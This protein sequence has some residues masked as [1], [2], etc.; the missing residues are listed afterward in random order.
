M[1]VQVVTFRL[2]GIDDAGFQV[3]CD[4]LAPAF[5]NVPGMLAKIWLADQATNTYGG[6]Y[7]WRDHA[8]MDDYARSDL[9]K[10]VLS[11]PNLTE[12]TSRD[13]NVLDG[14]TAVTGGMPERAVA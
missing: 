11:H 13:F 8:A 7:T 6:V 3:M 12:I 1:H 10:A 4:G 14:P 5:R 2:K 9:F